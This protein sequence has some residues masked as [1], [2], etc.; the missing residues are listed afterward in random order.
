MPT[1]LGKRSRCDK[2][3]TLVHPTKTNPNGRLR[4]HTFLG[5]RCLVAR[6]TQIKDKVAK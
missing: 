2:W 4:S 5:R 3:I 6:P 1:K